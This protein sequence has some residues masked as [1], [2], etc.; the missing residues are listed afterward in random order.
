MQHLSGD[1]D[2]IG[3]NSQPSTNLPS[4]SA[5]VLAMLGY[6]LAEFIS[7]IIIQCLVSSCFWVQE[8][9]A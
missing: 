1:Q 8:G 7:Q 4:M 3:A 5:T 2:K 9:I 6:L